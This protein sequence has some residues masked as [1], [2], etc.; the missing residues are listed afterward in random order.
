MSLFSSTR[1]RRLWLWTL[2]VVVAI[3]STLGLARTLSDELRSR[4]LIDNASFVSFLVLAAAV[5]VLAAAVRPGIVQISIVF[6]VGAVYALA[7]LRTVTPEVRSHLVEYTVVAALIYEALTERLS[8]GRRVPRPALLAIGTAGAVGVLDELIQL[9]IPS[10]VFDPIDILFNVGSAAITVAAIAMV[11]R[12]G[13][14]R[15][16]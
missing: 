3:Y 4:E 5:I 11:R 2:A 16:V 12:S 14:I 6:G 8:Q 13:R 15:R 1:E 9:L 10:R 7:F